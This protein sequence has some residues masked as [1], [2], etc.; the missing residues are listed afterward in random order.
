MKYSD[1]EFVI[2]K[3][4]AEALRRKRDAFRART[5][6]RKALF[7]T[8]VTTHGVRRNAYHDELIDEQLSMDAL[9]R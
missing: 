1:H 4:Y 7:L 2:T 6:T 5:R 9:F 8:L 3:A